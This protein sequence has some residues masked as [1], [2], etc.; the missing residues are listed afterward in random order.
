MIKYGNFLCR[1]VMF[2]FEN[3]HNEVNGFMHVANDANDVTQ[4]YKV[5]NKIDV[6][7]KP[8]NM[9]WL[10]GFATN[11]VCLENKLNT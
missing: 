3:S 8:K 10:D 9:W 1:F 7:A 6:N 4:T 5:K 2:T 11:A